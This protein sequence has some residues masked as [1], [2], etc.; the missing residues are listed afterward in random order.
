MIISL[1]KHV[2]NRGISLLVF[3]CITV[4]LSA[5][6]GWLSAWGGA[7]T[8]LYSR[9]DGIGWE[10]VA[11][12]RYGQDLSPTVR[13]LLGLEHGVS[14]H[15]VRN[16]LFFV[17]PV[18]ETM[19]Y[20]GRELRGHLAFAV[21]LG[22]DGSS[23]WRMSVGAEMGNVTSLHIERRYKGQGLE[24]TEDAEASARLRT[25]G[26]RLGLRYASVM[27]G[28][29]WFFAE[30]WVGFSLEGERT[31]GSPWPSARYLDLPRRVATIGL[32]LGL[33]LGPRAAQRPE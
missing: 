13:V 25:G 3:L 8:R 7:G 15:E 2:C 27:R 10:W 24:L 5:Q 22:G 11:G 14:S 19:T 21:R 32:L 26:P 4:M 33:E 9:G 23:E 1:N 12:I 30:P 17:P 18:E 29:V 31:V 16:T 28:P 6:P 20:T